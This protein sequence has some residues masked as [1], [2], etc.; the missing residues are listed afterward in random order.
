MVPSALTIFH[1]N[2]LIDLDRL[3][4]RRLWRST[5]GL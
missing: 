5:F 4:Y 2:R 3:I 1:L